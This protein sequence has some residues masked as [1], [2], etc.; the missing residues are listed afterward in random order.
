MERERERESVCVLYLIYI[1]CELFD[2]PVILL[3]R[4]FIQGFGYIYIYIIRCLVKEV[5]GLVQKVVGRLYLPSPEG[6]NGHGIRCFFVRPFLYVS[7]KALAGI[8]I[9]PTHSRTPR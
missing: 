9:A 1:V 6:G 7:G 4:D 5:S 2:V 8:V 3:L